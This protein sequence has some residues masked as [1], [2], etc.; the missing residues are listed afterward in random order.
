M[1]LAVGGAVAMALLVAACSSSSSPYKGPLTA[2]VPA[3]LVVSACGHGRGQLVATGLPASEVSGTYGGVAATTELT[4]SVSVVAVLAPYTKQS[5][6]A[7]LFAFGPS[8][9]LD[10]A[11]GDEGVATVDLPHGRYGDGISALV[12]EPTGGLLVLGSATDGFVIRLDEKGHVVRSFGKGGTVSVA[13]PDESPA[14]SDVDGAVVDRSG[15]IFVAADNGGAHCCVTDSITELTANGSTDRSYGTD[16]W[17]GGFTGAGGATEQL[18][19]VADGSLL[20]LNDAVFTGGVGGVSV[21]RITE[22]GKVDQSFA[23]NYSSAIDSV[24]PGGVSQ[25][26]NYFVARIFSRSNGEFGL[27]GTGAPMHAGAAGQFEI[28]IG[29]KADGT[30]DTTFGD[31]GSTRLSL[32][33]DDPLATAWSS[34]GT[35]VYA[36]APWA[37]NG[38]DDGSVR[39]TAFTSSG[40]LDPRYGNNGVALVT[41]ITTPTQYGAD[42]VAVDAAGEL[43]L[44]EPSGADLAVVAVKEP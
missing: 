43:L 10:R 7:K 8:C 11:F 12:P 31:H 20:V 33:D 17:I 27:T 26:F 21:S 32:G 36:G 14:G 42:V 30:L 39:I 19:L 22:A 6:R 5:D 23:Q 9:T 3:G 15:R 2:L 38:F 29:F 44:I 34:D 1:R 24:I 35:L 25:S 40:S 13:T 4:H 41:G 28:T 37:K 16:G 18:L